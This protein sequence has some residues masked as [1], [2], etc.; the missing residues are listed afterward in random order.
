VTAERIAVF[1][2]LKKFDQHFVVRQAAKLRGHER[3]AVLSAQDFRIG[4]A[5]PEG[6]Q[7]SRVP[8]HG[9]PHRIGDLIEV[10]VGEGEA[11]AILPRLRENGREGIGSKIVE[12]VDEQE[13][14]RPTSERAKAR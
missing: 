2:T 9:L 12:L 14:V 8:E 5:H 6:D 11:E 13:E 10:L 3:L 1:A 7:G 4:L